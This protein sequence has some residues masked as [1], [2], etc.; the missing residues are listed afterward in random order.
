MALRLAVAFTAHLSAGC[1]GYY[2]T[3]QH[4]FVGLGW[5]AIGVGS[6]LVVCWGRSIWLAL[7]ASS[8][9]LH[10]WFQGAFASRSVLFLAADLSEIM[11]ASLIL[12][13]RCSWQLGFYSIRQLHRILLAG[14]VAPLFGVIFWKWGY[15]FSPASDLSSSGFF[16]SSVLLW[17]RS[18]TGFFALAPALLGWLTPPDYFLG[19]GKRES[20]LVSGVFTTL[21]VF[22]FSAWIT[23]APHPFW[24]ALLPVVVLFWSAARCGIFLT[25]HLA[26]MLLGAATLAAVGGRALFAQVV[27]NQQI[28]TAWLVLNLFALCAVSLAVIASR[29]TLAVEKGKTASG[30]LDSIAGVLPQMVCYY[31]INLVRRYTNAAYQSAFGGV[32]SLQPMALQDLVSPAVLEQSLPHCQ[33]ALRGA[34]VRFMEKIFLADGQ[35]HS[36]DRI[37]L[38]DFSSNGDTCGFFSVATDMT[39]F[40]QAQEERLALETQSLQ[41]Q[42][43]ESLSKLAGRLAHEFNNRLFGMLG[44]ADIAMH[45]LPADHTALPALHKILEIGRE[46]SELCAQMFAFSGHTNGKKIPVDVEAIVVE[47]TKLMELSLPKEVRLFTT[48]AT[49]LPK[50]LVDEAQLRQ[51]LM[52]LVQNAAEAALGQPCE[53]EIQ[54]HVQQRGAV[55]FHESFLRSNDAHQTLVVISVHDNGDGIDPEVLPRIFDPFFST[56]SGSRGLGLSG[57]LGIIYGHQGA[58]LVHSKR[59]EGTGI[60][61]YFPVDSSL[62]PTAPEAYLEAR[63]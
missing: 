11:F 10:L 21:C 39:D 5:P 57:V 29:V 34:K 56:R 9:V 23:P 47:M 55:D 15:G 63:Q 44:H 61:L 28:A 45:A 22:A 49:D 1:L 48:F 42:K 17:M 33:A 19:P 32:E 52:N 58:L 27:D 6:V 2:L 16:S 43:L 40:L 51:A 41:T 8:C 35:L 36:L 25:T 20:V 12:N 3:S 31:D 37:L 24:F 53:V 59:G 18:A 7:F 46:A 38:P 30:R 50:V 54:V 62:I 60:S 4:H 14:V 13:W 26:L